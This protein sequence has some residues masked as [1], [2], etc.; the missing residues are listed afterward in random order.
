MT[1]LIFLLD[2]LCKNKG[3]PDVIVIEMAITKGKRHGI[4]MIITKNC[5]KDNLSNL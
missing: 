5:E 2:C 3:L 1:G 4:L